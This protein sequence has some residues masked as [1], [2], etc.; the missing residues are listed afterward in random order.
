VTELELLNAARD[1]CR[2]RRFG[3]VRLAMALTKQHGVAPWT[4]FAAVNRALRVGMLT[5]LPDR[6]L[7]P[8]EGGIEEQVG[9]PKPPGSGTRHK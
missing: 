5:M 8:I 9:A 1:L 4:A 6:T 2:T 3:K 7:A